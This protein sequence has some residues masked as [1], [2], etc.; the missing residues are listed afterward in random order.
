MRTVQPQHGST[1][2]T[3]HAYKLLEVLKDAEGKWLTRAEIAEAIHKRRLTPHD[4]DLLQRL[5]DAELVE[6]DAREFPGPIG[7]MFMYRTTDKGQTF[8]IKSWR[9][10]EPTRHADRQ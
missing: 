5:S 2:L 3:G 7:Y 9:D 6:I 1:D 8:V 4:V 10:S